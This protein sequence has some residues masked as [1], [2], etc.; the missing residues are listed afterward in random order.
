MES[1]LSVFVFVRKFLSWR[2]H[3][4]TSS[5]QKLFKVERETKNIWPKKSLLEYLLFPFHTELPEIQ[6][7]KNIPPTKVKYLNVTVDKS[8]E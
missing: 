5:K 6:L 3:K 7:R 2:E 1:E 8:I 4:I